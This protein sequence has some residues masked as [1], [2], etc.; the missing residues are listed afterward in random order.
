MYCLSTKMSK[1]CVQGPTTADA[2][3]PDSGS[4]SFSTETSQSIQTRFLA[5][6]PCLSEVFLRATHSLQ[7]TIHQILIKG[8]LI[9]K[10]MFC[11][12]SSKQHSFNLLFIF[13]CSLLLKFIKSKNLAVDSISEV[14][15]IL[16]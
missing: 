3:N 13:S 15:L 12:N 2:S 14:L 11:K 9:I 16:N 6:F 7:E 10:K 5:F 1:S 8:V 4:S